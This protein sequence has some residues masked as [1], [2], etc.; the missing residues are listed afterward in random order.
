MRRLCRLDGDR[1]R[2]GLDELVSSPEVSNDSDRSARGSATRSLGCCPGRGQTVRLPWA[3]GPRPA[4]ARRRGTGIVGQLPRVRGQTPGLRWTLGADNGSSVNFGARVSVQR[5]RMRRRMASTRP[6]GTY[7]PSARTGRRDGGSG[8]VTGTVRR[9]GSDALPT[10]RVDSWATSI[11]RWSRPDTAFRFRGCFDMGAACETPGAGG[12]AQ[13]S[14]LLVNTH[15][16]WIAD[17]MPA[18]EDRRHAERWK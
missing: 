3:G 11:R 17:W 12:L 14:I 15:S 9:A 16:P 7:S 13:S 18:P 6:P 4:A 2:H 10:V 5:P 1:D 8:G